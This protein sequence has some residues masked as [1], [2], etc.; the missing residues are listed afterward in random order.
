MHYR[1]ITLFLAS[2]L[3]TAALL[4]GCSLQKE[5]PSQKETTESEKMTENAVEDEAREEENIEAYSYLPEG[6]A[7]LLEMYDGD[8]QDTPALC[9]QL[10][11]Q[12]VR[13]SKKTSK[14]A[15]IYSAPAEDADSF[16]SVEAYVSM[17]LIGDALD[18]WYM[19]DYNGHVCYMR[20]EDFGETDTSETA[21][22]TD[23]AA[24]GS[25]PS[26]SAGNTAGGSSTGKSGST[27]NTADGDSNEKDA[28][29]GANGTSD[30]SSEDQN[31]D[32]GGADNSPGETSGEEG[33]ADSSE[34]RED[35]NESDDPS[36]SKEDSSGE[37]AGE[38]S[39]ST[40]QETAEP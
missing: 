21:D 4:G 37:A 25:G 6:A 38:E 33:S 26:V 8:A 30:T 11:G 7:A 9:S 15:E 5:D 17:N 13:S 34:S 2:L 24:E 3:W 20:A 32:P 16:G 39:D 35:G 28:D 14:K 29:S 40:V 19:V 22:S 18:G 1:K 36:G 23:A 12:E 31:E 10:S 27:G